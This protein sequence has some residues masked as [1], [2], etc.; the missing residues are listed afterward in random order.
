METSDQQK[1][2]FIDNLRSSLQSIHQ[3]WFGLKLVTSKKA[4]KPCVI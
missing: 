2:V 1:Q 3:A 4:M